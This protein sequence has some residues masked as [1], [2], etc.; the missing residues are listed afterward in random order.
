MFPFHSGWVGTDRRQ[1]SSRQDSPGGFERGRKGSFVTKFPP[2]RGRS[3]TTI[4]GVRSRRCARMKPRCDVLCSVRDSAAARGPKLSL[5]HSSRPPRRRQLAP[6]RDRRRPGPGRQ[7]AGVARERERAGM[8]VS[9]RALPHEHVH[10]AEPVFP[11]ASSSLRPRMLPRSR[12]RPGTPYP[13]SHQA[14]EHLDVVPVLA[15]LCVEV[16]AEQIDLLAARPAPRAGRRRW[17]GRCRRPT[18]GSRTRGSRGRGTC[19]R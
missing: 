19:S 11:G 15:A 1:A 7:P 8:P 13:D 5:A 6:S 18:S 14:A 4:R 12:S 10:D 2:R 9:R 16:P 3:S 17:G